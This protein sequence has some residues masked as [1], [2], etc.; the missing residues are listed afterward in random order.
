MSP[1]RVLV[2]YVC[3][4]WLILSSPFHGIG[5]GETLYSHKNPMVALS[6]KDLQTWFMSKNRKKNAISG[7]GRLKQN[8]F[9]PS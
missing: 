6:D 4:W 1:S 5:C 9:Y 7:R 3:G 2:M 8:F